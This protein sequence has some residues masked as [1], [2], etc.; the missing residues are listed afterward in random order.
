[1]R[2]GARILSSNFAPLEQLIRFGL[3]GIFTN[4]I[5]YSIYLIV[6]YFWNDPK[7][8]MTLMYFFG[9]CISFTGHKKWTFGHS[10]NFFSS[11]SRYLIAYGLGYILN[12]TILIL[13]VDKLGFMHQ[14]V[15]GVAIFVVAMYLFFVM[16]FFV[17]P[18]TKCEE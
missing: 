3:V 16:K 2:F 13:F 12:L 10:G 7:T 15:Q 1:M 14:W 11:V 4:L 9:V 18:E 5:G 6:T 17:F 8:V